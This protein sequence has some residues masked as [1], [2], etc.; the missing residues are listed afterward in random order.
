MLAEIAADNSIPILLVNQGEP[1]EIVRTYLDERRIASDDVVLD[2][3][4][5]LSTALR[6]GGLPSTLFVDARGRVVRTHLGEISRAALLAE[7]ASL[8]SR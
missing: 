8:E 7:L 5:D 2:R 3:G 4:S 6:I 1:A